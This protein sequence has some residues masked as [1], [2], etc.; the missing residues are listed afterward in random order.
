MCV[1]TQNTSQRVKNNSHA[2]RLRLVSYLLSIECAL[3]CHR[4]LFL[5]NVCPYKSAIL[6][7]LILFKTNYPVIFVQIIQ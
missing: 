7:L 1:C 5:Q 6:D 4:G 3:G 2:T